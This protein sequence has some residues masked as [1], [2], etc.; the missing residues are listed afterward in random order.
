MAMD[1]ERAL[2]TSTKGAV[3]RSRPAESMEVNFKLLYF[4]YYSIFLGNVLDAHMQGGV[5]VVAN[6]GDFRGL[7]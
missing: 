3:Q 5:L 1:N 6:A 4:D 2:P 7:F